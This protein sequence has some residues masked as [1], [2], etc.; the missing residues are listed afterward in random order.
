[1]NYV[2]RRAKCARAV[3]PW[4]PYFLLV[5]NNGVGP[6]LVPFKV[7]GR[8]SRFV[9]SFGASRSDRRVVYA[10]WLKVAFTNGGPYDQVVAWDRQAYGSA[11]KRY[12]G[13]F[14]PNC[15]FI[16]VDHVTNALPFDRP[17]SNMYRPIKAS[18]R[19]YE[20]YA[21]VLAT[22]L[23]R[24]RKIRHMRFLVNV[25]CLNRWVATSIIHDGVVMR[26]VP[27]DLASPYFFNSASPVASIIPTARSYVQAS[28]VCVRFHHVANRNFYRTPS[29]D[30]PNARRVV[31]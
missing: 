10:F 3:L 15:G 27:N 18:T 4:L 26:A 28:V 16:A 12:R 1:M 25:F 24:A 20:Y 29:V 14:R 22:E 2:S 19:A 9:R 5:A 6:Y 7:V 13:A 30:A 11:I 21:E 31:P 8:A 17:I 23:H